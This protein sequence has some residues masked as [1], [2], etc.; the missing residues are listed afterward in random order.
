MDQWQCFTKLGDALRS[1]SIERRVD[2]GACS[3]VSLTLAVAGR[4]ANLH[5]TATG[6][7]PQ[8]DETL[9]L[10]VRPYLYRQMYNDQNLRQSGYRH[11]TDVCRVTVSFCQQVF[12]HMVGMVLDQPA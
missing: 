8:T 2:W 4:M 12:R 5:A 7:N 3:R 10:T 9:V 6:T 1:G 11:N